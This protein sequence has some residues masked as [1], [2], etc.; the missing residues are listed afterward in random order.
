MFSIILTPY[1][2][3]KLIPAFRIEQLVVVTFSIYTC[4]KLILGKK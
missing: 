2:K 1:V 4:I 3:I